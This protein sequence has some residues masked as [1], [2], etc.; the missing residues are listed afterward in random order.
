MACEASRE[1]IRLYG[2]AG[3]A[4]ANVYPVSRSYR[5]CFSIRGEEIQART[6]TEAYKDDCRE[7]SIVAL[8]EG[9]S[10]K[11]YPAKTYVTYN[12]P[13][14]LSHLAKKDLDRDVRHFSP[15]KKASLQARF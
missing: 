4:L 9:E 3:P 2:A 5:L 12:V 6:G 7:R 1:F 13:E 14:N 11:Y 8:F 15:V 10:R